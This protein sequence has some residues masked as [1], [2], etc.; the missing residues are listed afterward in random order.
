M[1]VA[2]WCLKSPKTLT[3]GIRPSASARAS[4][5]RGDT[6]HEL[7]ASVKGATEAY[8]FDGHKPKYIRLHLVR[9]EVLTMG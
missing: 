1:R 2:N 3:V 6:W 4:S 9:N 5:R 7:R 8:F